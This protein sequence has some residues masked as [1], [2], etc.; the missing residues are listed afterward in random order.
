[1][2][3]FKT[4]SVQVIIARIYRELDLQDETRWMDIIEWCGEA[5]GFIRAGIQYK[6]S[7]QELTV[8]GGR[9]ELPCDF[10]S[11]NALLY[12]GYPVQP[13]TSIFKGKFEFEDS[14]VVTTLQAAAGLTHDLEFPYVRINVADGSKIYISYEAILTDEDGFPLIPD[15]ISFIEALTKYCLMKMALPAFFRREQGAESLYFALKSE[16][17][18]YCRQARGVANMPSI[19][20][21]EIIKSITM[22]LI[23]QVNQHNA[24]F[25]ELGIPESLNF[26][27]YR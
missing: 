11:L 26:N 17:K 13:T 3:V 20:D 25:S 8:N 7:S 10:Y 12:N 23:P 21:L 6:T 22:R 1:M 4:T 9:A 19:Q 2:S 18:E 24:L 27:R 16:W 5:L 14:D 15:D